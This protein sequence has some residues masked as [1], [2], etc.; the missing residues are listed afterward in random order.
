[1]RR[2]YFLKRGRPSME[3]LHPYIEKDTAFVLR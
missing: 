1:M 3:F 2:G